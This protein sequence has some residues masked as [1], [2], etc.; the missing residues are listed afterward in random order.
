MT[1][2]ATRCERVREQGW[3]LVDQELEVGLRSIAV[4]VRHPQGRVLAA[5]NLSDPRQPHT[6]EAMRDELL[7]RLQDAAA[8]IERDLALG[9]G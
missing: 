7:P 2:S 4:P 3:S 9:P 1:R 8:A 6:I 5:I